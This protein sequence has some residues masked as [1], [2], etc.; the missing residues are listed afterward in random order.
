MLMCRE[1]IGG[2]FFIYFQPNL[3]Y[4]ICQ[5]AGPVSRLNL[6]KVALA[7]DHKNFSKPYTKFFKNDKGETKRLNQTKQND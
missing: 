6:T 3:V 2:Y 5:Q 4:D 1:K 7:Y